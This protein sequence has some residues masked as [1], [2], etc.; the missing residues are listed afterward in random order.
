MNRDVGWS[1]IA[2]KANIYVHRNSCRHNL[3]T[4][5][6]GPTLPVATADVRPGR[7]EAALFK[8]NF[9]SSRLLGDYHA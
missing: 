9:V 1:T 6:N 2:F 8:A 3:L 4:G 7:P 5:G